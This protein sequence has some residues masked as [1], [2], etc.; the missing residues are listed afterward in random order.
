MADGEDQT[1]LTPASWLI[2]IGLAAIIGG[3][4]YWKFLIDERER[5]ERQA[6]AVLP[7]G[8]AE[9]YRAHVEQSILQKVRF[10]DGGMLIQTRQAVSPE[11]TQIGTRYVPNGAAF[12]MM[13]QGQIE[14]HFASGEELATLAFIDFLDEYDDPPRNLPPMIVPHDS[15]AARILESELCEQAQTYLVGHGFTASTMEVVM[16][17]DTPR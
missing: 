15:I 4:I 3:G 16:T 6:V 1:K 8:V 12:Y 13:C 9:A 2:L 17:S 5:E 14:A 11:E 7:T 10:V